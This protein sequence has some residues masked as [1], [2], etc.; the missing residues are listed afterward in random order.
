MLKA[1]AASR[2]QPNALDACGLQIGMCSAPSTRKSGLTA[3]VDGPVLPHPPL[4]SALKRLAVGHHAHTDGR[5]GA[6]QKHGDWSA[7]V[8]AV[9]DCNRAGSALVGRDA[10]MTQGATATWWE[11]LRAR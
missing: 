3:H 8:Y 11:P 10:V 6:L 5:H 1:F 2:Y 7:T 4:Q 9:M